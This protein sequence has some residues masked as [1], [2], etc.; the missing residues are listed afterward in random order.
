MFQPAVMILGVPLEFGRHKYHVT[1]CQ[2]L[3]G[4]SCCHCATD[5]DC[6]KL[7]FVTL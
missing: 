7:I 5:D 6:D 4:A 3:E 2:L 1:Q